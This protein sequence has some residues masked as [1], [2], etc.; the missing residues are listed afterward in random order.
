MLFRS[1][2]GAVGSGAAAGPQDQQQN[3]MVPPGMIGGGMPVFAGGG[4]GQGAAPNVTFQAP[5]LKPAEHPEP[6]EFSGNVGGGGSSDT[7]TEDAGN[8]KR[9]SS[10]SGTKLSASTS[11]GSSRTGNPARDKA[12]ANSKQS[13]VGGGF[14]PADGGS[15]F[16]TAPGPDGE[17]E[18]HTS[19]QP[20]SFDNSQSSYPAGSVDTD[21]DGQPDASMAPNLSTPATGD[22]GGTKRKS[23]KSGK[24]S[25]G[26][27]GG[28]LFGGVDDVVDDAAG[29]IGGLF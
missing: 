25:G 9:K 8:D 22:S 27:S 23:S 6:R 28:G 26:S 14:T 10:K 1:A 4:R 12:E 13:L 21:G 3:Q 19:D 7:T 16:A 2:T 15:G 5:T 11:S 17:Q 18:I 29:A 20:T 24:K